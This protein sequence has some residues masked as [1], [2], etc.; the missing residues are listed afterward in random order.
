MQVRI[1]QIDRIIAGYEIGNYVKVI[2]DK[3]NT[4]GYLI[5][6][7]AAPNMQVGFDNWVENKEA[8]AGYFVE[9]GWSI[10]WL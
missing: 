9:A 7:A 5:L 6:I 4:G 8:L 10:E 3:E 2:D 1:G